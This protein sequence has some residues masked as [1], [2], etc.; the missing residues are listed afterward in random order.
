VSTVG[1]F[2]KLKGVLGMA[3]IKGL[4]VPRF[5]TFTAFVTSVQDLTDRNAAF[6]AEIRELGTK[7]NLL[8]SKSLREEMKKGLSSLK[9]EGWFSDK[10]FSAIEQELAKLG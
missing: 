10:E 7:N 5:K 2:T 8:S 4:L 9:S 3:K 6:E 1:V